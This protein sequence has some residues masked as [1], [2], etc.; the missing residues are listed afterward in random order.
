MAGW[1]GPPVLSGLSLCSLR[2]SRSQDLFPSILTGWAGRRDGR[3]W[4]AHLRDLKGQEGLALLRILSSPL[5]GK[6]LGETGAGSD[7]RRP[8]GR[9]RRGRA[10]R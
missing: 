1:M 8:P 9:W 4:S 3:A 7:R 10:D 5:V 2:L 6:T